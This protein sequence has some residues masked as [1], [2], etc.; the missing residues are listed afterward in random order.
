MKYEKDYIVREIIRTTKENSNEPLGRDRFFS[1]TGI[2]QTDWYGKYWTKWSD[3]LR[4]AGYEPNKFNE[5]YEEEFLLE[6]LVSFIKEINRFPVAG[7]LMLK[8]RTD[9]SFPSRN[10][11]ERLGKQKEKIAKVVEYCNIAVFRIERLSSKV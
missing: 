7:D 11:F 2:K 6:K 9:E 10:V 4:E 3:A 8:T 5:A 1:A